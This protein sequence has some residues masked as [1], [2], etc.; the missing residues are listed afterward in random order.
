MF[1]HQDDQPA[2]QDSNA[3]SDE[4]IQGALSEADDQSQAAVAVPGITSTSA[5]PDPAAVSIDA[6]SG[7][8]TPTSS[9]DE[10]PWQHPGAPLGDSK[11]KEPIKDI[12]SPAGGFP[13]KPTY[14]YPVPSISSSDTPVAKDDNDDPATAALIDIKN[15][16]L[17][18][19]IPIIDKLDLPPEEKFRTIMMMIQ[20]SDNQELVKAAYVA[21][22]SIEDESARAQALMDII[23]EVNY[24]TN[25]RDTD[26]KPEPEDS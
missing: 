17:D 10:Q 1:G 9:S 24:F 15:K 11:D 25:P 14:Q 16:A 7:E 5:V 12:I 6:A 21:A 2:Q 13:K 18:E 8:P 19:L 26:D 22:H 20:A 23:N 3:I 4:S